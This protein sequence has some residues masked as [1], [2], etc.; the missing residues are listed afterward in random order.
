[1]FA[2]DAPHFPELLMSKISLGE[3]VLHKLPSV[4]MC[5]CE[6]TSLYWHCKK[7]CSFKDILVRD[8]SAFFQCES[9]Y[10]LEISLTSDTS[11]LT[12]VKCFQ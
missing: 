9:A 12:L 5:V 4:C 8:E 1:M 10:F 3:A 6:A 7:C 11:G 2:C